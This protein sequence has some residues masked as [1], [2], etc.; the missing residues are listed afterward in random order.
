MNVKKI[1]NSSAISEEMKICIP[2]LH[3][4]QFIVCIINIS[5]LYF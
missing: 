3:P 1:L 4:T 5:I 2:V